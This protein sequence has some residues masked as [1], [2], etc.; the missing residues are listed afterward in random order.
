MTYMYYPSLYWP[1]CLW[2]CL[3][4]AVTVGRGEWEGGGVCVLK[5][6]ILKC[7]GLDLRR[8]M[9]GL[10][11]GEVRKGYDGGGASDP[12]AAV[13]G[14]QPAGRGTDVPTTP[15]PTRHVCNGGLVVPV[16]SSPPPP[17]PSDPPCT[18]IDGMSSLT[19]NPP[20]TSA[21]CAN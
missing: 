12:G 20:R 11:L 5:R 4:R 2:V 21:M 6:G 9:H 7:V 10:P 13:P 15:V 18:P 17:K 14:T 8:K 19:P 16:T 1:V 3:G